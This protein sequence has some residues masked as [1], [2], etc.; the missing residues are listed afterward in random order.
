MIKS[1]VISLKHYPR[2]SPSFLAVSRLI[3]I[4]LC[5]IFSFFIMYMLSSVLNMLSEDPL[6]QFFRE[7]ISNNTLLCS[8]SFVSIYAGD[9]KISLCFYLYLQHISREKL[10]IFSLFLTVVH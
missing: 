6:E 9:N 5:I 3:V 10:V 7:T 8:I 4:I 1:L 2:T